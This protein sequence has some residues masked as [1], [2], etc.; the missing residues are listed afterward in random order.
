LI[1]CKLKTAVSYQ[2]FNEKWEKVQKI[3]RFFIFPKLPLLFRDKKHSNFEEISSQIV[4]PLLLHSN[5]KNM[6]FVNV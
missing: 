5:L 2:N 4:S 6:A 1:E 3:G